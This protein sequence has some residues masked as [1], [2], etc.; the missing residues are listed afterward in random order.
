MKPRYIPLLV[1]IGTIT[2]P[3]SAFAE[4]QFYGKANLSIDVIDDHHESNLGISSNLSYAGVK[5]HYPLPQQDMDLLFKLE[6]GVDMSGE[7]GSFS[8]RNR[9]VGI[10]GKPGQ[11][12]VGNHY[13]P[14]RTIGRVFDA[15]YDTLADSRSILGHSA[16]GTPAVY[17]RLAS[18]S[19]I[20]FTPR[21]QKTFLMMQYSSSY[22]GNETASGADENNESLFSLRLTHRAKPFAL[23]AAYEMH[24][25]DESD[26]IRLVGDYQREAIRFRAVY[27][28][29]DA[30]E[31]NGISRDAYGLNGSYMMG[32]YTANAQV[33]FAED[34]EGMSDSSALNLAI[35]VTRSLDENLQVYGLYTVT[36]NE[37]NAKYTLGSIG[38]NGDRIKAIN[39]GDNLR[40]ISVGVSYRFE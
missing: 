22:K 9:Y 25:E 37:T 38:H 21:S 36:Y 32:K 27:E 24:T 26:G 3:M 40:G 18:N 15:F 39:A 23:H 10:K 4:I 19:L 20:L 17:D 14:Y 12:M 7:T 34:Y 33:L 28:T 1:V 31:G 2:L 29:I 11:I 8:A 35:G 5:G 30:G 6:M 13:T 16:T